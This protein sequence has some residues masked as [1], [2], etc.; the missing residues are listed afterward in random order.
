MCTV[1]V[2]TAAIEEVLSYCDCL[3]ASGNFLIPT[4]DAAV[5]QV[6][7]ELV[8][9]YFLFVLKSGQEVPVVSVNV[10]LK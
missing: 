6:F 3:D 10:S 4:T 2:T 1:H 5:T 8:S 7:V 9:I